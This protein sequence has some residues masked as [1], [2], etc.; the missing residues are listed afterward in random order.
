[1]FQVKGTAQETA[2]YELRNRFKMGETIE[3]VPPYR[4]GVR[5]C[6]GTEP[7]DKPVRGLIRFER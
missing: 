2:W 4:A 1:M 7:N 6:L 5:V 3:W